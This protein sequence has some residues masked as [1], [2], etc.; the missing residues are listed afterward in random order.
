MNAKGK[1]VATTTVAA[2]KQDIPKTSNASAQ[3]AG[4]A[5][6]GERT[7][8][9]SSAS[10]GG[11]ESLC[12]QVKQAWTAN[13]VSGTPEAETQVK[14]APSAETPAPVADVVQAEASAVEVGGE[15]KSI[16]A[17]DLNMEG[18]GQTVTGGGG[19]NE[20][21]AENESN[22]SKGVES[23]EEENRVEDAAD[24]GTGNDNDGVGAD[25]NDDDDDDW[26]PENAM[27]GQTNEDGARKQPPGVSWAP[28]DTEVTE[29]ASFTADDFP[30]L[31]GEGETAAPAPHSV[32]TA[33][34]STTEE[35]VSASSASAS[36]SSW[37][38]MAR[39]NPA[40]FKAKIK[41]DPAP[42]PAAA[43]PI[44]DEDSEPTRISSGVGAEAT[45]ARPDGAA[46]GSSRILNTASGFGVTSG[47]AKEDDGEGWVN[48][49]NI[50]SRRMA[51]L[52]LNG[53]SQSQHKGAAPGSAAG[54]KCRAGCVTT[55]FA[56]QNVI[57][58]VGGVDATT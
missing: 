15:E 5:T 43:T 56:M 45:R 22:A 34:A 1:E 51:G 25:E 42:L 13:V 27:A 58:Q 53:P 44:P 11:M 19:D 47:A 23:A 28:T 55:D 39:S 37:S 52:G 7:E 36:S 6:N 16:R 33:P 31:G 21:R 38:L 50:K 12:D 46:V 14:A 20:G 17:S 4:Q 49:S 57:L 2:A 10:S 29:E 32:P 18:P 24:D 54:S 30:A 3:P 9:D 35:P 26:E 40:P 41:A 48:P 8:V